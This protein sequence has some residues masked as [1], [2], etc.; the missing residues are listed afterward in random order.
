MDD[1]RRLMKSQRE[2]AWREVARRIA[3]EIKNPLTPIKLSAQ[4]LQ[5]R[6]SEFS[7]RDLAVLQE[8]TET[9][10]RNTDELKDLV[11][12]VGMR[13]GG[14]LYEDISLRTN[15]TQKQKN[16]ENGDKAQT[17]GRI[18]LIED[19]PR[20]AQLITHAF[21]QKSLPQDFLVLRDGKAALDYFYK[22]SNFQP[23]RDIKRVQLII[24]DLKLPKMDGHEVLRCIKSSRH[25]RGVPVVVMSSSDDRDEVERSYRE[26]SNAYV[27]KSVDY[28]KFAQDLV[29][30]VQFWI[31]TNH[32][33]QNADAKGG[34][35][36]SVYGE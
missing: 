13:N 21:V 27:V 4:R 35:R 12:G 8:C 9:I 1:A 24:L 20:D 23:G 22:P 18:V 26:G 30:A 2:I 5:R 33:P 19:D 17:Q 3:H 6:F 14:T 16:L 7:G 11:R 25:L 29:N 10:I 32:V 31:E 34:V 15:Q 36:K 28:N